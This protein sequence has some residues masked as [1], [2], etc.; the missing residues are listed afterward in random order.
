MNAAASSGVKMPPCSARLRFESIDSGLIDPELPVSF[1]ERHGQIGADVEEL[2]LDA[3]Q[4]TIL[5][6]DLRPAHDRVQLVHRA[7]RLDQRVE[8]RDA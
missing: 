2:V 4:P 7:V 1:D 6:R 8:L 5:H 3:G